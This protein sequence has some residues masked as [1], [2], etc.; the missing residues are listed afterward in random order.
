MPA[1]PFQ[2]LAEENPMNRAL[3]L[4]DL[5]PSPNNI[6]VR[7]ALAY[8]KIPYEKVP[9]D[10]KNREPVVKVSGQPLCPV[11]TDGE[12]VVYDSYAIMR[13]LDANFPGTPRL[14]NAERDAIKKIKEWELFSRTEIGPGISLIFG[15]FIGGT[16]DAE[17]I[18]K[19]NDILNR[20]ASRTEEALAK[21][22]YLMGESPNAADFTAG[23]MLAYGNVSEAAA[24][25]HPVAAFFAKH[26]RLQGFP[27]T[28]AWTARVMEWDR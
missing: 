28:K 6:K 3:K 23:T 16:A 18:Q 4:Y 19:A 25:G 13:Y 21:T 17:K 8:K 14:Y 27:K 20:A 12:A 24:K 11:L 2:A 9:V 15:Q 7:C 5:A 26:V 1:A 22:P 10:P